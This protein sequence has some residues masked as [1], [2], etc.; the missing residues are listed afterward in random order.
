MDKILMS[1]KKNFWG[2]TRWMS[3][4]FDERGKYPHFYNFSQKGK[5][6]LCCFITD[7]FA[8]KCEAKTDK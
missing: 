3:I 2:N 5:H 4:A 6:I 8:L 1:F 7:K